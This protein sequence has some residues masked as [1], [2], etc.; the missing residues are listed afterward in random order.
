MADVDPRTYAYSISF[1]LQRTTVETAF[2]KVPVTNDLM[3]AQPDGTGRIDVDKMVARAI[4]L[5]QE[6]TVLWVPESQQV[7]PHPI[8]VPP[9]GVGKDG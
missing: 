5:G 9:P 4:E 6:T 8:Q 3:I 2:I 7:R 1:R